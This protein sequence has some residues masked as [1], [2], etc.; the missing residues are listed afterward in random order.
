MTYLLLILNSGIFAIICILYR[1]FYQNRNLKNFKNIQNALQ[2]KL[3]QHQEEVKWKQME[4]EQQKE[5]LLSARDPVEMAY[6]SL[7]RTQEANQQLDLELQNISPE[8]VEKH[9]TKIHIINVLPYK[10]SKSNVVEAEILKGGISSQIGYF[11]GKGTAILKAQFTEK[12]N[13]VGIGEIVLVEKNA[14]GKTMVYFTLKTNETANL[15][16]PQMAFVSCFE[17]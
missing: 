9:L 8:I 12:E 16:V 6:D 4:I 3:A 15:V 10:N 2:E 17:A 11:D 7:R 1:Q 14:E 5:E 13:Y